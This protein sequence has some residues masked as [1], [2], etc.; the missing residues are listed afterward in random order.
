MFQESCKW[1]S[2]GEVQYQISS[3]QD[4]YLALVLLVWLGCLLLRVTVVAGYSRNKESERSWE[5]I[6]G[7]ES[8]REV[9]ASDTAIGMDL[10][11][12]R[13]DVIRSVSSSCEIG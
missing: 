12:L 5:L 13:L 7:V 9:Y 3:H 8:V 6:L 1:K 2:A 11:T 4:F 10:D